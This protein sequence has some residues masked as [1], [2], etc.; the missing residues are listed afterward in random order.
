MNW[1]VFRRRRLRYNR[2]II[3]ACVWVCWGTPRKTSQY[4]RV[5]DRDWKIA[6][7][8]VSPTETDCSVCQLTCVPYVLC[9]GGNLDQRK[10]KCYFHKFPTVYRSVRK[11]ER[12]FWCKERCQVKEYVT[13]RFIPCFIRVTYKIVFFFHK[14]YRIG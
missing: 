13:N 6:H 2:G 11:I 7:L 8:G 4:I 14:K 5:W 9:Y 12:H 10:V 3:T 1:N